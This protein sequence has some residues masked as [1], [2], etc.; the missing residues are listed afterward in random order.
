MRVIVIGG[1]GFLGSHI[2]ER[3]IKDNV[4]VLCIDK[5]G[6]DTTFLE[7]LNVPI[8][9]GNITDKD[10]IKKHIRKGDMVFHVAA[11]L[12]AANA[13]WKSYET[14]NVQGT[15]NVL[16]ASIEQEA[17]SFSFMSTYGIYGPYQGS[18]ESPLIEKMP[19][20]PYSYYDKSKYLGEKYIEEQAANEKICC[21]IFRS[22]VIFGP[23]ANPRSGTGILFNFLKKGLFL[24]FGNTKQKFSICYVKNLVEAFVFFA[25]RNKKGIHKYNMANHP[26][27]TF[28]NFL[29]EVRKYYSFR[30]VKV[31]A[32]VGLLLSDTAAFI[33][34]TTNTKPLVP[35][36]FILGLVSDAYN[37][38]IEK[39]I[40]EGYEEK[41]SLAQGIKETVEYLESQNIDGST[42]NYL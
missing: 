12:G 3:L 32:F 14:I 16:D 15:R 22:P 6:C 19:P 29:S 27:D 33:S 39:A 18:L 9:Y 35:K 11:I 17:S 41:Y 40:R 21:T 4:E 30:L 34:K 20:D 37:S 25:H 36:D 8:A 38:S 1:A 24:T 13:S 5:L 7:K 31:P 10:S 23:R 26:V 28:E 42:R 2:I